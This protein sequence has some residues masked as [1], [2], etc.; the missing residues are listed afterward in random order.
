MGFMEI[1]ATVEKLFSGW[2]TEWFRHFL[3]WDA[4]KSFKLES[5]Y[6]TQDSPG[7]QNQ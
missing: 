7:K 4:V 1:S 3:E 5:R 2:G 6:I